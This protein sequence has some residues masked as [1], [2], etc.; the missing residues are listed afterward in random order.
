MR[1]LQL[2]ALCT[3]AAL[4]ASA[5]AQ[6]AEPRP[7]DGAG[8]SVLAGKTVGDRDTAFHAA[9][10]WPGLQL[11][12]LH[13]A[14][15]R[16]D[17]GGRLSLNYGYE[18][19]VTRVVPGLKLQGVFRL[20]LLDRARVNL[21]AE[22]APGPFFYFWTGGTDVGMAL[23]VS[24]TLGLLAGHSVM[25]H[26]V[27]DLPTFVVFGTTGRVVPVILFGGGLEYAIDPKLAV[28]VDLRAGPA[29]DEPRTI[30]VRGPCVGGR[31]VALSSNVGVALK[32]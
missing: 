27:L 5:P 15:P 13:G 29:I 24:L 20:T 12:L 18:G 4:S 22:L 3:A 23:P 26:L 31:D 25:L 7:H 30:C 10:G 14:N 28:T 9:A 8:W 32:L 11:S 2:L 19:I 6:E 16:F 21:G 17:L 1:H